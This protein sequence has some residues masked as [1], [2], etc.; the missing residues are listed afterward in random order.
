VEEVEGVAERLRALLAGRVGRDGTAGV[1]I[2]V[3]GDPILYAVDARAGGE[4]EFR[5]S[6]AAAELEQVQRSGHVGADVDP[7]IFDAGPHTRPSCEIDHSVEALSLK[8]G[9]CDGGAIG[10]VE[11]LEAEAAAAPKLLESVLLQAHVVGVVQVVDAHQLVPR[12][13]KDLGGP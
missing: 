9:R 10:D 13:E 1:Q 6:A 2:L 3:V 4:H 7:G 8:R 12:F 5:D 11:A